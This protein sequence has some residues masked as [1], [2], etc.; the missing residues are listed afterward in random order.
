MR[1]LVT[2]A[3]GFVGAHTCAALI[4][5]GHTVRAFVRSSEKLD[6]A[7]APLGVA[8]DEVATG[9]VLDTG[10]V[11][12]AASGCD[13]VVNAANVY[14]FSTLDADEMHQVNLTGTENVL[15]AAVDAGCTT[16]VHV[17]SMVALLPSDGPI[18]ADPPI[19]QRSG[20]AYPDSKIASEEIARRYQDGGAPVVTVYPGQVFGPHD[21]GG[22][23]M[24]KISRLLLGPI[25][26]GV[27]G[28]ISI[29]DVG[30]L[31]R[32]QSRLATSEPS[33]RRVVAPGHL[34]SWEEMTRAIRECAGRPPP[35]FVPTPLAVAQFAGRVAQSIGRAVGREVGLNP[36]GPW[37]SA[38]WRP[39]DD[40]IARG[41]AG[42][43]PPLD[44]TL[45]VAIRSMAASGQ[46]TK[47]ETSLAPD[48]P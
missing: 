35:R 19:G 4:S 39:A 24:V 14:R 15:S 41:I 42:E 9:D 6:R 30:W 38:N 16:V 40:S 45:T 27:K 34:L 43:L 17:S 44:E 7:M 18:P 1:A 31:A 46:L 25:V 29:V 20:N 48:A 37:L 5:E 21:P 47:R 22:G 26:P 13:S 8:P 28:S 32:L 36:T 23:E 3:S 12:E 11:R 33:V 10:S 2:G